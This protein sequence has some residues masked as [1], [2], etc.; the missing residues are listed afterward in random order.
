MNLPL[1]VKFFGGVALITAVIVFGTLG[2]EALA[3]GHWY[4]TF[5]RCG[6]PTALVTQ[7]LLGAAP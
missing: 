1:S 4:W 6:Y 7:K 2:I 3:W 5:D